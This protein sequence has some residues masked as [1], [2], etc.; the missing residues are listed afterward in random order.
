MSTYFEHTHHFQSGKI[1]N[2][3]M[4]HQTLQIKGYNQI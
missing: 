4:H 3:R 1:E 2:P